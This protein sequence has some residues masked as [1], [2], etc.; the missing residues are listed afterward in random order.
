MSND[1]TIVC[2]SN[3]DDIIEP[4]QNLVD[5]I[6]YFSNLD[7]CI[8]FITAN[9]FTKIFF[10]CSNVYE[11]C[12]LLIYELASI[13]SIYIFQSNELSLKSDLNLNNCRKFRGI[14]NDIDHLCKE[15]FMNIRRSDRLVI[16][17]QTMNNVSNT[18]KQDALFMYAQLLKEI[19]LL[20]QS[21]TNEAKQDMIEYCRQLFHNNTRQL[22][23][24]D[25]FEINSNNHNPIWFYT[26][27]SFL[28]RILNHALRMQDV[29]TLYKFRYFI[30]Q[31]HE[32]IGQLYCL[33]QNDDKYFN[34]VENITLYRGQAIIPEEFQ[35]LQLNIG[36]LLSISNFLST[37]RKENVGKFFAD[38]TLNDPTVI[39]VCMN[40]QVNRKHNK[41][42]LNI[43]PFAHINEISPFGQIEDEVLLSMGSVFRIDKI[44]Q[45]SSE[46]IW[47]M[48]LILTDDEDEQ[49]RLVRESLKTRIECDNPLLSLGKLMYTKGDYQKA[50]DFFEQLL[51]D[52]TFLSYLPNRSVLHNE[53]AQIYK[54]IGDY[55]KAQQFY[56]SALKLARQHPEG[57]YDHE[58]IAGILNNQG[59]LCLAEKNYVKA[60]EY[61]EQAVCSCEERPIPQREHLSIFLNNIGL[62]QYNLGNLDQSIIFYNKS[63]KIK[64]EILPENH[65]AIA[66]TLCNIGDI[67]A[68]KREY[69]QALNLYEETLRIEKATLPCE[70]PSLALTYAHIGEVLAGM[71]RIHDAIKALETAVT[72]DAMTL[73]TNNPQ[74]VYHRG[75]L[76]RWKKFLNN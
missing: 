67:Y 40:I 54:Q 70:H 2:C 38:M 6:Y 76:D 73:S 11:Y 65:P 36:G 74:L 72:I 55:N 28:Y 68:R 26:S 1:F 41:Q 61:F 5:E 50:I 34:N 15:I 23:F 47:S 63:L 37:S 25:E 39:S 53:L 8:D 32:Q 7:E 10:I 49:L 71:G 35:K 9:T 64:R 51:N 31:L 13:D 62:A 58:Y 14:F 59:V 4:L 24:I 44:E 33:Q 42:I 12:T 60:L 30:K 43:I 56:D 48:N 20:S 29:K 75:R 66:N 52:Q 16:G 19:L 18:N 22:Q 46:G 57:E 69:Q 45:L 17:F 21:N 27:E 3:N